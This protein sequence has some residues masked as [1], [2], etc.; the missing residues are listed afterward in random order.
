MSRRSEETALR[1]SG[2]GVGSADDEDE[3]ED[4][5]EAGI[6]DEAGVE[7]GAR[8]A[9]AGAQWSMTRSWELCWWSTRRDRPSA[10]TLLF[11]STYSISKLYSA[12]TSFQR[13]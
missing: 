6:E 10:T 3:D 9:A 8:V 4:E 2:A 12:M 11:P 13:V 5:D 1:R 7:A